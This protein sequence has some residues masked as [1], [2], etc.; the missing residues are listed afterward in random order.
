VIDP[1]NWHV[2]NDGANGDNNHVTISP[3]QDIEAKEILH[4]K[5]KVSIPLL[6]QLPWK[7]NS[8]QVLILK[9]QAE[10]RE[11][12]FPDSEEWSNC[13]IATFNRILAIGGADDFLDVWRIHQMISTDVVGTDAKKK[14]EKVIA[15]GSA[16]ISS[17]L[18][19]L[20]LHDRNDPDTTAHAALRCLQALQA[21][22]LD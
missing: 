11:D 6:Q 5:N 9:A 7:G 21:R 12:F 2:E 10:W 16:I 1:A 4:C 14:F 19:D 20:D 8:A 22:F 18:D 3:A 13:V 17:Y 15:F